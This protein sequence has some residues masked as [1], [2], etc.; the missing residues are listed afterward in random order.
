MTGSR[1]IG[2]NEVTSVGCFPGFGIMITLDFLIPFNSIPALALRCTDA[3]GVF[4][5]RG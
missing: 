3:G 5:H 4:V 2:L 1:L